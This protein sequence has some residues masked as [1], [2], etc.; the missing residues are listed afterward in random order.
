MHLG[1]LVETGTTR[2]IFSNPVHPYTRALLS[3]IP[4]PNPRVEKNRHALI[5]DSTRADYS[6]ATMK[7]VNNEHFVLA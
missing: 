1:Y 7:K 3:A 4:Y 5:Y 6:R 2:E